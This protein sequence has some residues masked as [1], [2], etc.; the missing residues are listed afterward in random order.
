MTLIRKNTNTDE[1]FGTELKYPI[2]TGGL[3]KIKDIKPPCLNPEHNPPSHY[4]YEP[5]VYEYICPG[6]GQR[7]EFSVPGTFM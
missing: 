3:R 2:G 7:T 1:V 6:C 5:G 4:N